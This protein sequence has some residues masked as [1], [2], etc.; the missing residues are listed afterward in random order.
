MGNKEFKNKELKILRIFNFLKFLIK[1]ILYSNKLKN[2]KKHSFLI[3]I[4]LFIIPIHYSL[5]IIHY[6]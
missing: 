4:Y 5:F 3:L 1:N 2:I 6:S